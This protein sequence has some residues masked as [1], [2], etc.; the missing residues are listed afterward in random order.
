MSV[1]TMPTEHR[2]RA[3]PLPPRK[4]P[5]TRHRVG[6]YLVHVPLLLAA[7]LFAFPFYWLVVMATSDTAEIFAS[8]PRLVPGL[9]FGSNFGEVLD[10]SPFLYAFTNSVFVTVVASALQVFFAALAGFIFAKYR[11]PGRDQLFAALVVTMALPTGVAIVP[12]FQIYANLGWL[13]SYWPL[14]V[15]GAA[16]AFGI[17][18][19]RQAATA[20]IPD[21]LLEAARVDGAGFWRVFRHVGLPGLSATIAAFTVFQVM[22]NWNEYLWPLLVLSDTDLYTLPLALQLLKGAYGAVDYSVVMAGTLVATIPLVVLF[23][24]FRRTVMSNASA[25]AVKG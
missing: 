3:T 18:W 5:M 14:L 17:F 1:P 24:I 22:W 9:R 11:F 6:G 12:N 10:G 19:M 13:N 20:A 8:P 4:R 16:S 2:T 15:P 25:G 23:L 21:E 7:V